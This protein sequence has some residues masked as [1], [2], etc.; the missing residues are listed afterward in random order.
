[1]STLFGGVGLGGMPVPTPEVVERLKAIDPQLGII[2]MH[3]LK[4]W[5]FIWRWNEHDPRR[6]MIQ[7]GEM[8]PDDDF[9]VMEWAPCEMPIGDAF[10]LLEKGLVRSNTESA[11]DMVKR[12]REH[13]AQQKETN[14]APVME[15]AYNEIEVMGSKLFANEMGSIPKV[16]SAGIPGQEKRPRGRPRKHPLPTE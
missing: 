11:R 12:V 14:A 16:V 5:A 7:R 13:N 3:G 8:H 6:G 2:W 10:A 15:Q 1:M 9:D 4:A